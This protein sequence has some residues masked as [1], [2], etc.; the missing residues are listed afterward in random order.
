MSEE[1]RIP[2][3]EER[4]HISKRV[5]ETERVRVRSIPVEEQVTLREFVKSET[6]EVTRVPVGREV[7]E[8]P[9]TRTEGDVTIIPVLEERLVIEKRLFLVEEV[10]LRRTERTE[11]IDLDTTL[12]RTRVDVERE[13]L[14]QQ[15]S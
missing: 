10:H 7:A 6:V 8:A 3:V 11:A 14:H 5:V 9:M 12:R 2:I 4:A 1:V 13:N 15:E